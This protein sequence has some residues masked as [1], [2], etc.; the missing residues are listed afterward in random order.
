MTAWRVRWID[1]GLEPKHPPDPSY[2][3]GIDLRVVK[4]DYRGPTCKQSLPY[5]AKRIGYF[6]IECMICNQTT[7]VTTAGRLDD[8][9]S[10]EIM[11]KP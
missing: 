3:D 9:R 8:P 7:V 2:P 1:R 4:Q 5:P 10:I 6:L 11:C